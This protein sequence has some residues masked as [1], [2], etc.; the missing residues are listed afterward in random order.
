M[1][2]FRS[3]GSTPSEQLLAKLCDQT[4]LGFWRYVNT[5]R[6]QGGPKELCDLLVVYGHHIILFSDKSC[7]LGDTGDLKLDWSRW[8]RSAVRDS[9]NQVRGAERWLKQHPERVFV[10]NTCS[11]RLPLSLDHAPKCQFHRVIVALGAQARCQAH[12][13]GSGSLT[14]APEIVGPAHFDQRSE[15]VQPF[16]VGNVD[17]QAGYL[18]VFDDFTLPL[19]LQEVDTIADFIAYLEFKEQLLTSGQVGRIAGEENLLAMFLT[20]FVHTGGWRALEPGPRRSGPGD[21][22]RGL[23][24]G[25]G[26][27][28]VPRG[29]RVSQAQLCL[30]PDH[31]G[32]CDACLW[33]NTPWRQPA[34][35]GRQR[36]HVSL[37]GGG[38]ARPPRLPGGQDAE[39]LDRLAKGSRQLPDRGFADV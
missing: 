1:A 13:G 2:V 36:S 25:Q 16:C 21:P 35:R 37:H 24:A 12:Q 17:P 19:V 8:F 28:L 30:G 38:A 15:D 31:P 6:D 32:V 7:A 14:L 4:F 34:V 11:Q 23:G 39:A 5:F 3:A 10:D 22:K 18:H 27:R 33:R 29:S 20:H 9:A 26:F